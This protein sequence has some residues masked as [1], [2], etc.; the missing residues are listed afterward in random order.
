MDGNK[1]DQFNK[2]IEPNACQKEKNMPFYLLFSLQACLVTPCLLFRDKIN[3]NKQRL[4]ELKMHV[5]K[6]LH[7]T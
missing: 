7:F 3:Q 6:L 4:S 2:I 1:I 5:K